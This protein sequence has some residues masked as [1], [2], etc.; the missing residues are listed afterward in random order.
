MHPVFTHVPPTVWRST[1]A[2][3]WP[4]FA[5]RAA[6]EGPACPVPMTIESYFWLIVRRY[7]NCLLRRHRRS[8]AAAAGYMLAPAVFP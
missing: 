1:I 6:S 2:T 5:S 7:A 8:A 4:A 3:F